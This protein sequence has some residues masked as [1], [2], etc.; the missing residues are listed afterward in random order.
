MKKTFLYLF[1]AIAS[2][3]LYSCNEDNNPGQVPDNLFADIVTIYDKK[4][5][6]TIFHLQEKDDSPTAVLTATEFSITNTPF[7]K[8]DRVMIS[9]V[10]TN[11]ARYVSD[12]ISVYNLASIYPTPIITDEI[13]LY[14]DWDFAD[15]Y[16][17]D[18][19]RTGN[20]INLYCRMTYYND[21]QFKVIIDKYTVNNSYPDIYLTYDYNSN[22]DAQEKSFIASFDIS[23][24]WDLTTCRGVTIH[25]NSRNTAKTITLDKTITIKPIE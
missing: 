17:D 13:K 8:G 20:Y 3:A 25:L 21:P 16:V 11:G 12:F 2:F 6:S 10:P 15:I 24:V 14:P 19:W 23:E 7:K 9:Y 4:D 18:L 1:L 22:V 5:N